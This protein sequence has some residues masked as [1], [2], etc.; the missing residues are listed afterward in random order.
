MPFTRRPVS[1]REQIY[2]SACFARS[3][4]KTGGFDGR[5]KLASEGHNT[6]VWPIGRR[7]LASWNN[8][9]PVRDSFWSAACQAQAR[10]DTPNSWRTSFALFAS[11][12]TNG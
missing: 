8:S 10:P 7:Q 6:N 11:V 3:A 5:E 4:L 12:R 1:P 2:D 9:A